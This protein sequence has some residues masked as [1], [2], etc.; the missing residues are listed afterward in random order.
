MSD[1]TAAPR[2]PR[3]RQNEETADA[4]VADIMDIEAELAATPPPEAKRRSPLPFLVAL[5]TIFTGLFA[6][7]MI[8][9]AHDPPVFTDEE[10]ESDALFSLFVTSQGL[11]AYWD[12]AGVLPSSLEAVELDDEFLHY[13]RVNDSTYT[14]T[15][16]AGTTEV[17]YQRGEDLSRFAVALDVLGGGTER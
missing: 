11:E 16:A 2:D 7:N 6:W 10:L 8:R 3:E 5:L 1:N 15:A 14:L 12:S 13:A 4:I 17:V 9:I